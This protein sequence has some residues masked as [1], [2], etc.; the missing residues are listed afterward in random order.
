MAVELEQFFDSIWGE[1][2]GTVCLSF[3]PK[4]GELWNEFYSWPSQRNDV[5]DRSRSQSGKCDVYYTPCVLRGKSRNKLAF[6]S[7]RVAWADYDHGLPESFALAPTY[8]I[9]TSPDHYHAYWQLDEV[10]SSINTLEETNRQM[11][12][13]SGGDRCWDGTRLLR[14][15]FTQNVKRDAPVVIVSSSEN[16]YNLGAFPKV[17][18]LL[19]SRLSLA[20]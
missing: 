11:A 14:V 2:E 10:C 12:N 7:S 6:K 8:L 5:L 15:P 16:R 13:S 4:G 18:A 19:L 3:K 1:S 20:R 9:E 17:L